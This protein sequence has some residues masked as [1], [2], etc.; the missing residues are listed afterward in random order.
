MTERD[1]ACCAEHTKLSP[2][3]TRTAVVDCGGL[4][5]LEHATLTLMDNRTTHAARAQY[6]CDAN[7]TLVG[8]Q[9]RSCGDSGAWTGEP[10]ECLCE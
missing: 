5:E 6:V 8:V 4:E 10:P 1:M 3:P 7:Y 2:E 9:R